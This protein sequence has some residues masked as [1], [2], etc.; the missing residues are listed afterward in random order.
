MP[1]NAYERGAHNALYH[2]NTYIV[3]F[4]ERVELWNGLAFGGGGVNRDGWSGVL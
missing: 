1:S 4:S 3:S 2:T